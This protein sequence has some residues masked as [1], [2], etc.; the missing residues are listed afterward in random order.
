MVE[1][2]LPTSFHFADE[3]EARADPRADAP[4]AS[5]APEDRSPR[6]ASFEDY[7][8]LVRDVQAES[9]GSAVRTAPAGARSPELGV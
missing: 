4:D 7:V 1:A 5:A 2:L 3:D 6:L 8:A 9:A